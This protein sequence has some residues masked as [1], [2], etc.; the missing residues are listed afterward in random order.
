MEFAV[1][2]GVGLEL[3]KQYP[4]DKEVVVG[5]IDVKD[6]AVETPEIVAGRI[7]QALEFIPAEKM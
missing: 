7:R 2:D 3:F 6:E 1:S 5:V 4:T